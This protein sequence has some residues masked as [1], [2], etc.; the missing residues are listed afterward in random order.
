MRKWLIAILVLFVLALAHETYHR[1]FSFANIQFDASEGQEPI[2][3]TET[4][5]ESLKKITNQPFT[6]LNRG[7][8]SFVFVSQDQKYVLKF[9]DAR[10]L[11]P[12]LLQSIFG[13]NPDSLAR[14]QKRLFD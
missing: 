2:S 3:V 14:K 8:Q 4:Q 9:F 5:L 7:K 10:T 12:S 1:E 6:Y 11:K 13:R